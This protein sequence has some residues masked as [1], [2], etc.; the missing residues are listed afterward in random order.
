M[1]IQMNTQAKAVS[2]IEHVAQDSEVP[3]RLLKRNE[4]LVYTALVESSVPLKAYDLLDALQDQGLR[5]P[6]TIYRALDALVAKGLVKKIASINAFFA[7][8]KDQSTSATA[9]L[10][11]RDCLRTK[12][13][14][15][16]DGQVENLFSPRDVSIDN[17]CIEA[18]SECHQMCNPRT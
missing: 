9:F 11:C 3:L 8:T 10:I 7:V 12:L 4:L 15:L 17:V 14:A 16:D 18:F 13:I 6:M 5:A 1:G 2:K